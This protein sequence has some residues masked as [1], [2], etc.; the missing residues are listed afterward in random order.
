VYLPVSYSTLNCE[1]EGFVVAVGKELSQLASLQQ[2]LVSAQQTLEKDFIKLRHIETQYR[3]LFDLSSSPILICEA[4]EN[5]VVEINPASAE[6]LGCKID[7]AKG[8]KYS[9]FFPRR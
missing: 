9:D 6:A 5:T 3:S 1:K 7:K 4:D 2:K 8:R